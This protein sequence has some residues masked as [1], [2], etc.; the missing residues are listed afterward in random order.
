MAFIDVG[1]FVEVKP[2]GNRPDLAERF[3]VVEKFRI[4]AET[5][6][7]MVFVALYDPETGDSPVYMF[8]PADLQRRGTAET[9][10]RRTRSH[11]Q[12]HIDALDRMAA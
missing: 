12:D 4:I 2:G 1:S 6:Y 7:C 9:L 10:A 5:G 3:G 8:E 11:D